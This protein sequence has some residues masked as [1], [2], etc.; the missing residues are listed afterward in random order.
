MA[1]NWAEV[2]PR[3]NKAKAFYQNRQPQDIIHCIN[4]NGRIDDLPDLTYT[5]DQFGKDGAFLVWIEQE[6]AI[7]LIYHVT[8]VKAPDL[9]SD[10]PTMS[11][12]AL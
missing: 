9:E 4:N 8:V 7:R 1:E 5:V 6:E 11:I 10:R 12:L 3:K 2:L